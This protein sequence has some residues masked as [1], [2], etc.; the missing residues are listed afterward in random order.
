[1][2]AREWA[3]FSTEGSWLKS[4]MVS[5]GF[6]QAGAAAFAVP[7]DHPEVPVRMRR[8]GSPTFF[9]SVKGFSLWQGLLLEG[10]SSGR[11]PAPGDVPAKKT[12]NSPEE[13]GSKGKE[14]VW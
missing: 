7:L 10:F 4:G 8:V 5:G 1:M 3:S 6:V 14:D 11:S 2:V 13:I 12:G 9:A